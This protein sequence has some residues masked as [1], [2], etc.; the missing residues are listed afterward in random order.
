MRYRITTTFVTDRNLTQKELDDLCDSISLQVEE[1][2]DRKG[3]ECDYETGDIE[4]T[5]GLQFP[6]DNLQVIE[7]ARKQSADDLL[8]VRTSQL[9]ALT[10]EERDAYSEEHPIFYAEQGPNR[11]AVMSL[12]FSDEDGV[13]IEENTNDGEITVS[14]F[15]DGRR[16]RELTSGALYE[17]A[18]NYYRDN[19]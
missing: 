9:L 12:F 11:F 14:Y 3:E 10:D 7:E 8:E 2:Q 13:R 5:V 6:N 18:L 15:E 19:Y 16:N 4:T 1:P 17:W